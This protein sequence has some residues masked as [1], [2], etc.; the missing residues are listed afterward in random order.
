MPMLRSAIYLL[1]ALFVVSAGEAPAEAFTPAGDVIGVPSYYEVQEG[2]NLYALAR[3]LDLGIVE[4]LAANLDVDPWAPEEGMRL[5]LSTA[6]VLPSVPRKGLVLN[7]AELR[8]FY[9]A[10]DGTVYSYPVG[11]GREG[12]QTPVGVTTIRK[13]RENP[14]WIPPASIRAENP[15]LPKLVPA[16][17]DNPMGAYA[18]DLA[19][20]RYAIHGTNKPGGIGLRSSHGCIRLYPEDIA[21]LFQMVKEG[22]PVMVVDAPYKL[23]WREDALFLEV[24][25]T[26]KQSDFIAEYRQPDTEKFPGMH[27]AIRQAAGDAEIHWDVVEE[28]AAAHNG[29]PVIIARR[30]TGLF[31]L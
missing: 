28:A 17:P 9:F 21:E 25:P 14:V 26:Q 19:W 10:E 8:L 11:I 22:T 4:L 20:K 29:L 5:T 31:G 16:G 3:K 1:L 2:D 27:E 12:W 23:G 15:D 7:L 13:K 18:L 24:T 30:S 6:H